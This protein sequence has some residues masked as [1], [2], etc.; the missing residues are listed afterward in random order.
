MYNTFKQTLSM[1]NAFYK[2]GII[3]IIIIIINI[4]HIFMTAHDCLSVSRSSQSH[5]TAVSHSCHSLSAWFIE[6]LARFQI[7]PC[8]H[9]CVDSSWII[10]R[11]IPVFTSNININNRMWWRRWLSVKLL[12]DLRITVIS[13]P[14]CVNPPRPPSGQI[15]ISLFWILCVIS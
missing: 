1:E 11:E 14:I 15:F 5:F 6:T 3:I 2:F 4:H 7:F 10:A 9:P 8:K 12:Q 13:R